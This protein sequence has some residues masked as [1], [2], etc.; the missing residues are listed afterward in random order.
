MHF[1][2]RAI[3]SQLET[4][5]VELEVPKG[6]DRHPGGRGRMQDP[7]QVY[8]VHGAVNGPNDALD[9]ELVHDQEF[10]GSRREEGF[11]ILVRVRQRDDGELGVRV[12]KLEHVEHAAPRGGDAYDSRAKGS[13]FD[14]FARFIDRTDPAEL[15]RRC[16]VRC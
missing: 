14:A 6:D 8:T 16:A 1:H 13:V 4:T 15:Q 5:R 2:Q 11:R 3:L 9:R 7:A 10:L 12:A